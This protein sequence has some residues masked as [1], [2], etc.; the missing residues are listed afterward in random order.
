MYIVHCCKILHHPTDRIGIGKDTPVISSNFVWSAKSS[1]CYDVPLLVC[2]HQKAIIWDFRQKC[3]ESC[4]NII[5]ASQGNS[6]NSR[7]RSF[8]NACMPPI[9][10]KYWGNIKEILRKYWGN[11][12]GILRKC[13]GNM[14][15]NIEEIWRKYG[16][17][18]CNA[19]SIVII[20]WCD[21]WAGAACN[22]SIHGHHHHSPRR[23]TLDI[24]VQIF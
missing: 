20:M 17:K 8:G 4:F 7:N 21:G 12:R 3:R 14:E 19:G 24:I 6:H 9:V 23:S 1:L 11:V 13:C 22:N 5:R 16:R 15:K 10:G 2:I 18:G